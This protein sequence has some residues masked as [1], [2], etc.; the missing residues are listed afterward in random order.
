MIAQQ[1]AKE[2]KVHVPILLFE[3][4]RGPPPAAQGRCS[5]GQAAAD[6]RGKIELAA[7]A[8]PPAA[9]DNTPGQSARD[10]VPVLPNG[11]DIALCPHLLNLLIDPVRAARL[12]CKCFGPISDQQG[13]V[14]ALLRGAAGVRALAVARDQIGEQI[15]GLPSAA[16]ALQAESYQVGASQ[17]RLFALHAR[18]QGGAADRH[19]LLIDAVMVTPYAA[20]LT[21][22]HG[23]GLSDLWQLQV[24]RP[25]LFAGSESAAG[26]AS[27][28]LSFARRPTAVVPEQ[29]PA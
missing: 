13:V 21:A 18:P 15:D 9:L 24:L 3:Q 28:P 7:V 22:E 6:R 20:R 14:V 1:A 8:R 27:Q 23:Q 2:G 4:Q 19:A 11:A 17:S 16:G 29:C 10:Q 12:D 26:R 25:H 5:R